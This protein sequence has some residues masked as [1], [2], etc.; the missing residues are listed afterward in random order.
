MR[1]GSTGRRIESGTHRWMDYVEN[2]LIV[3]A[4]EA[5]LTTDLSREAEI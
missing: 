4:N 3:R 2:M 5:P 1:I